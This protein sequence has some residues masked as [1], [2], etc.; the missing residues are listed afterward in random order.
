MSSIQNE[1]DGYPSKP[2]DVKTT[3]TPETSDV[4]SGDIMVY[5]DVDP[6]LAGKMHLLNKVRT[7]Y[8]SQLLFP[9]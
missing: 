6:A 2:E 1:T 7:Y 9:V 5:E 3:E 8:R 4:S